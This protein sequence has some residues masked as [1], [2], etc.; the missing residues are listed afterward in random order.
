ME[1]EFLVQEAFGVEKAIGGGNFLVLARD[2]D[3]ALGA[4][5]RR[6]A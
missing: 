4:A 5:K 2:Q 3:A 1:G 6:S